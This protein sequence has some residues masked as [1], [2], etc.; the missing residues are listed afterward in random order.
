LDKRKTLRDVTHSE[1][2]KRRLKKP[3]RN[4]EEK[5]NKT[6]PG[7][8]FVGGLLGGG[9]QPYPRIW[10]KGTYGDRGAT[11]TQNGGKCNFEIRIGKKKTIGKGV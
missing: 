6:T 1:E 4:S 11:G 5:N 2:K 8:R 9:S 3:K 10:S 7:C